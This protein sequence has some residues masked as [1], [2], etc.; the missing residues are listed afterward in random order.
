MTTRETAEWVELGPAERIPLGE[1]RT[2]V[3]GGEGIA[4]FRQRDG[5]V[6]AVQSRCPHASGPLAEGMVG[7][8]MVICP[9]HSYRFDLN[10]GECLND[11]TVCLRT[12]EV[13]EQGG[14][15][16]VRV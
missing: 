14:E 9:L 3:V 4:V 16:L 12:F 1:G 5:S 13:Q 10:T 8:G 2:F 15:L 7:G 6:A 11:P